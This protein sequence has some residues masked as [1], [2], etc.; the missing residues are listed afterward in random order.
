MRRPHA[1]DV[2]DREDLRAGA[3]EVDLAAAAS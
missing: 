3:G 1:E 2:S